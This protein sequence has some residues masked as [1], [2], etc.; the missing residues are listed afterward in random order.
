MVIKDLDWFICAPSANEY[1][2]K[3]YTITILVVDSLDNTLQLFEV[4]KFGCVTADDDIKKIEYLFANSVNN[5]YIEIHGK[6][7]MD[8]FNSMCRSLFSLGRLDLT[9]YLADINLE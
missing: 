7:I 8:E 5:D 1:R 6:F 3:R 2:K 9:H 4:A